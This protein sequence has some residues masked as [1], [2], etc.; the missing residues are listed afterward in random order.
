ML[1]IIVSFMVYLSSLTVLSR[2]RI[3]P[4]EYLDATLWLAMSDI[5]YGVVTL[6]GVVIGYFM[7]KKWWQI[8]YVDGVYYF[9]KKAVRT[10][11]KRTMKK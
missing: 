4:L 9:D 11:R 3:I 10:A 6:I 7:A 2:H 5:S 8:I 1:W